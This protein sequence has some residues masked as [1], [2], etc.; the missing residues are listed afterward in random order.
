MDSKLTASQ[1]KTF[2]PKTFTDA[3]GIQCRITAKVRYDDGCR[4]GHNTFSIT[5][6]I[7]EY[8]RGRWEEGS[9]GCI[10]EEI[11]KHFPELQHLIKWHLTSSDGPM[12]YIAN[13]LYH[14]L[15]HGPEDAHLYSRRRTVAG[16]DLDGKCEK[17]GPIQRMQAVVDA[18]P[19]RFYL[20]IDEKTAKIRNLN[21]ARDSAVWP[22]AT[23]E[24]LTA[25]GL[26]ERLEAR[27]PALMADFRAAVESLGF[28]Y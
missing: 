12:H 15:Q 3:Y 27:L 19:D 18:E 25:P 24:D 14:A 6:D 11:A 17:Y 16:V 8:R 2:G 10:H 21:A 7:Q 28:T 9:G 20:K 4:N 13:T 5:G 23:D 22:D 26:K 1:F